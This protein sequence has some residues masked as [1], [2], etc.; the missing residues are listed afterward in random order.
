MKVVIDTLKG[1]GI[2]DRFMRCWWGGAPL[3]PEEFG[4]RANSGADGL[5]PHAA[6]AGETAKGNFVLRK[7][8]QMGPA[9]A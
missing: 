4:P 1:K 6:V 3:Q 8:N 5:L 2:R 9:R 7:H